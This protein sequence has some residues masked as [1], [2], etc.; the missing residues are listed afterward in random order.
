MKAKIF[1]NKHLIGTTEL[2]VGDETM[3]GIFGNFIPTE[4]YFDKIQKDVWEFWETNKPDYRK[5]CSLRLNVQLVNGIFLFPQGGFTID[6]IKELPDEP[7]RIDI[8]GV[9][10]KIIQDFFLT[11][12]PR[13]FTEEPWG[14][15]LIEQKIAFEDELTKEI[16]INE[17]S[18]FD[19]INKK[20]KHILFDSEFSAFCHDQRND[21][22]L[23]EVR[24]QGFDKQFALVHL[25]WKGKGDKNHYPKT[26]FYS[27]FDDFKY[28]RMYVDKAEWEY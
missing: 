17:K 13:P 20:E 21:D 6:D 16:G 8:F 24:K 7:K 12:P 28:S 11:N 26:T 18:F 4:M 2:E 19:F 1:S 25:T 14:E 5:W 15:L 9:N 3:G 22:V 27:D 10:S 23:F